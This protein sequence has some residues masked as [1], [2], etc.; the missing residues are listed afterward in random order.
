MQLNG[1]IIFNF[2]LK[3]KTLATQQVHEKNDPATPRA[4]HKKG[5]ATSWAIYN[6]NNNNNKSLQLHGLLMVCP[7]SIVVSGGRAQ[8]ERSYA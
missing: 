1:L 8:V 4:Y 7:S 6:N 2:F 3:Q 5:M